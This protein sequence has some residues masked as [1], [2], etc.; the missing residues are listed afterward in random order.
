ME[1]AQEEVKKLREVENSLFKTLKTAEDPGANMIE[2]ATRTAELHMRETEMKAD[3]LMSEAKSRA[4]SI[5]EDAEDKARMI[6]DDMEDEIRQLE[7]VFRSLDA[8]KS[9]LMSDLKMLAEDILSKLSRHEDFPADIKPHLK[10][11]KE[12]AREVNDNV[13]PVDVN[14]IIAHNEKKEAEA[15]ID[16]MVEDS[17]DEETIAMV[18]AIDEA[19]EAETQKEEKVEEEPKAKT[20]KEEQMVEETTEKKEKGSFFDQFD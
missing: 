4:K 18:E 2:Q 5:I 10:K 19:P 7:Q 1:A 17:D 20:P 12:L 15:S 8:N 13:A 3:A 16:E 14:K 9:S 6:V 11:A